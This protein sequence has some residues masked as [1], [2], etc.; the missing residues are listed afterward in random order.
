MRIEPAGAAERGAWCRV[1][2]ACSPLVP[3]APAD[4]EHDERSLP[5]VKRWL[6]REEGGHAIACGALRTHA[7][8][9]QPGR[10]ALDLYVMPAARRAGVGGT[11]LRH[12]MDEARAL[13]ASTVR[14]YAPAG[15]PAWDVLA[16]RHDLLEVERDRFCV[17]ELGPHPAAEGTFVL[18]DEHRAADAWRLEERL[19]AALGTAAPYVG[20]YERWRARVLDGPGCGVGNVLIESDRQGRIVGFA[21]MRRLAADPATA[22]HLFTGVAEH[23]RGRGIAGKLKGAAAAWAAAH[24]VRRLVADT[25]PGNEPMLRANLAAG[26]Q[27]VRDVRNLEGRVLAPPGE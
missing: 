6:V 25:S 14:T 19:H 24:G 7:L 4:L 11:L 3:L 12:L 18:L 21:A 8:F 20:G 2:R 9:A 10:L 1:Q 5:V 13:G 27:A 17:R 16:V 22:Y 15:D 26:Y 23:A